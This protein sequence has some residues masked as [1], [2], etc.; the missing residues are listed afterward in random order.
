MVDV[1]VKPL[2]TSKISHNLNYTKSLKTAMMSPEK[3][4]V[5][6]TIHESELGREKRWETFQ[7][8]LISQ[9][10]KQRSSMQGQV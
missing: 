10:R 6:E 4:I 5:L 1:S 3:T 2:Y 8:N 7:E 9:S